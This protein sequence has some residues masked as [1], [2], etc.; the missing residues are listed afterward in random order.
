MSND[1][2]TELLIKRTYP[3]KREVVFQA[4]TDP[5]FLRQWFAP[6]EDF[7]TADVEIDLRVGGRFRIGIQ[8]P[9]GGPT[10]DKPFYVAGVYEEIVP[11]EKLVFT[12]AWEWPGPRGEESVVTIQLRQ[13]DDET[14]LTLIHRR[15]PDD[16]QREEHTQGWNAM[17]DRLS[18]AINAQTA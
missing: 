17:L 6:G 10:G 3:A 4:W 9:P 11:P 14:E 2:S 15:L 5:N 12:W 13:L 7:S 18:Q 1:N 8:P 16:Q